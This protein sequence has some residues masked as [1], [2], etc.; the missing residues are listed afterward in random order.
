M[1]SPRRLRD[2]GL[3]S[4]H[5]LTVGRRRRGIGSKLAVLLALVLVLLLALLVGLVRG[6]A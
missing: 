5:L 1:D 3:R 4:A 6:L 2:R